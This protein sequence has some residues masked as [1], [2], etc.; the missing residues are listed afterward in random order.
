M[1]RNKIPIQMAKCKICEQEKSLYKNKSY[2]YECYKED[3]KPR[4][5]EIRNRNRYFVY[6][7]LKLFGQCVD[8]GNKD[9]RVLEFDHIDRNSKK[10]TISNL[11]NK[12]ISIS[13][14]KSEMKKCEIRCANCHKIKTRI[15]LNWFNFD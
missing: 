8:C 13:N 10:N 7:F 14:L 12:H 6:R 4:Q 3:A 2:C 11:M 1:D 15:Q 5:L 9:W